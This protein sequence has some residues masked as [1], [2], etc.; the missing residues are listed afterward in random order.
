MLKTK[1]IAVFIIVM[2]VTSSYAGCVSASEIESSST[3]TY[4]YSLD[5]EYSQLV[6]EE[7][8]SDEVENVGL[9]RKETYCRSGGWS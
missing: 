3:Y 1:F 5:E 7:I 2:L 6:G 8:V 4:A 9:I